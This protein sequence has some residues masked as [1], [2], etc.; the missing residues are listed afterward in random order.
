[1]NSKSSRKEETLEEKK[2]MTTKMDNFV[3]CHSLLRDNT[4]MIKMGSFIIERLLRDLTVTSK[5]MHTACNV[6]IVHTL[7][8]TLIGTKKDFMDFVIF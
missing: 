8:G 7:L 2:M 4:M 3:M 6:I 5:K 1:M